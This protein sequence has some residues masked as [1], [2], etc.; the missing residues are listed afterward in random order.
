MKIKFVL[1]I[2]TVLFVISAF[3]DAEAKYTTKQMSVMQ[4]AR[5]IGDLFGFEETIQAIVLQESS[6]GEALVGDGGASWGVAHV[7]VPAAIDAIQ[8][9]I[10]KYYNICGYIQPYDGNPD[11]LGIR[12][13]TQADY[14]I[15]L[16][17]AYF[18]LQYDR[19]KST[20]KDCAWS[21]ALVDYNAGPGTSKNL[22]CQE[23]QSRQYRKN[24]WNRLNNIRK[25]NSLHR[26]WV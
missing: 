21:R 6:A 9:C 20:G 12:L 14:N 8:A 19:Y 10:T 15:V 1:I 18:K 4:A 17:A 13:A 3:M 5:S 22:S 26:V 25:F 16:A 23:V 7:S 24:I 11:S 2:L